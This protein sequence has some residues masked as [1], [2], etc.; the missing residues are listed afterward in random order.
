M[1]AHPISSSLVSVI[2]LTLCVGC[3]SE[4]L[5][6]LNPA[7]AVCRGA[8]GAACGDNFELGALAV[9]RT[10]E[11]T[12]YIRNV[13]AGYLDVRDVSF[14]D[15]SGEVLEYPAS[16][17]TGESGELIFSLDIVPDI[18]R[19]DMLIN[20]NDPTH[21]QLVIEL[22]YDGVQSDL[23]ACPVDDGTIQEN[24][25]E[26][27][28]SLAL[29]NVRRAEA[30]EV[31]IAIANQ[32][33]AS[34]FLDHVALEKDESVTGEWVS[35][36]STAGGEMPAGR[37]YILTFR[38]T[39]QDGSGDSLT[40]KFFEE[41]HSEATVVVTLEADSMENEPPVAL[42]TLYDTTTEQHTFLM[43][44]E[45]WFDGLGSFDPE[46]DELI[47]SWSVLSAPAGSIAT[48]SH[49]HAALS[50][51]TLDERGAYTLELMVQDSIGQQDSAVVEVVARSQYALEIQAT[52]PT[53]M[54]DVDL[55]MMPM[56]DPLFGASDCHFQ[57]G[58]AEWGDPESVSDNPFLM[59]DTQ[60][61]NFADESVVLEE[62]ANGIYGI[63]VHYFEAHSASAIPVSVS[64]WGEDGATLLGENTAALA[65]P[66]DTVWIGSISWPSGVFQPGD[67]ASFEHCFQGG[68]P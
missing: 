59:Y 68:N 55:H 12:L 52:W 1:G 58:T 23:V 53:G 27:S 64:V 15:A 49:P 47:Y 21:P 19:F 56:G 6:V 54:G 33:T 11:Q 34:Y 39:P 61:V 5:S 62:P 25:C 7:I 10:H 43:G 42:P 48:F 2:A 35:L 29:N 50:A 26:P 40:L 24:A 57:N 17:V 44:T 46:G 41:D 9:G 31:S 51:I 4:D 28:L 20:S 14:M 38:Y 18:Q 22:M 65:Q 32:G 36:T 8:D 30:H 37:T 16:L 45:L 13:G 3:A 60:G 63:Y 67:P 66:C